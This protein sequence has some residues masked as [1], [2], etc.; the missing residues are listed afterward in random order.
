MQ[1]LMNVVLR[2]KKV[3]RMRKRDTRSSEYNGDSARD[4][5]ADDITL[6]SDTSEVGGKTGPASNSLISKYGCC[7]PV[8]AGVVL[9]WAE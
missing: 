6:H 3:I 8:A 2:M 5:S 7:W 4:S 1:P 9:M